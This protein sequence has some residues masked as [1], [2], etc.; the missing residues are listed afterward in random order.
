MILMENLQALGLF[1]E[2]TN[3]SRDQKN[4]KLEIT[5]LSPKPVNAC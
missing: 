2:K 1:G 5:N 4:S 3:R